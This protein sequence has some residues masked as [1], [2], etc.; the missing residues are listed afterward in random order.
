MMPPSQ[1]CQCQTDGAQKAKHHL[2]KGASA[3]SD[4]LQT[5]TRHK[6]LLWCNASP[7]GGSPSKGTHLQWL[8]AGC[9]TLGTTE[10]L[11]GRENHR[12]SMERCWPRAE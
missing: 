11:A 10:T 12:S 5:W 7:A 1:P 3:D 9:I 8:C 2:R 6:W 4:P